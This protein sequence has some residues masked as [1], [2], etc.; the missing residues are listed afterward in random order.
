MISTS[1]PVAA[2]NFLI[3]FSLYLPQGLQKLLWRRTSWP[4]KPNAMLAR[5][6]ILRIDELK[7]MEKE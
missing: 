3:C 7:K 1:Y 4:K 6:K 5:F 2:E